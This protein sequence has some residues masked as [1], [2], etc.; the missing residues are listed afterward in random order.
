VN[1]VDIIIALLIALASAFSGPTQG[2]LTKAAIDLFRLSEPPCKVADYE[3]IVQPKMV[4][5]TCDA[6]ATG[7]VDFAGMFLIDGEWRP[8]VYDTGR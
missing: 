5:A 6:D 4:V 3:F 8:G 2:E 1:L 7:A